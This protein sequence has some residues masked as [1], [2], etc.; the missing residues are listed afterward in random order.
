MSSKT[1]EIARRL[2]ELGQ[3]EQAQEAYFLVL[4]QA[5]ERQ[6]ELEMEAA[7]YLFFSEGN[8]RVAY[9]TFISL[10]NRG[11]YQAELLDLMTQAFYLPNVGKQRKQYEKNCERLNRYHYLFRKDF[12]PF[13]ELPI[14]FFPF[15]DEG[16]IP[17]YPAENR[18][19][20]Y[21]DFRHPVIDRYFF[22]DLEKPILAKDV[23]SQYQLEYLNDT[24]RKSEWVG[25]ENHIYLHYSDWAT[26][27][28]HL[29]CLDFTKQLRDSK[30]V[31]LIEDEITQYP[32]D[33]KERF[34]IDYSKYIPRRIGI[35]EVNRLIWQV[36]LSAHNGGNFFAEIMDG[37]PYLLTFP[38]I[39]FEKISKDIVEARSDL[40]K[41]SGKV[42][43]V[44]RAL[45]ELGNPSDK[46]ILVAYYMT[47]PE[48]KQALNRRSRIVPAIYFQPHFPDIA[49]K[50]AIDLEKNQTFLLSDQY[51]AIRQAPLFKQFKYVK[52][53]TP[54][55][56][57]TISYAATVRYTVDPKR[58]KERGVLADRV[59]ERVL[60][61]SFMIDWQDRLFQDSVLVRFE[62]GKLN[63]KATFTALAE[64]LD[65]P[66]TESMTYCS[67]FGE[68]DPESM[69]GD[70]RGFDPASVYRT[71]DEYANDDER[72]FLEY[73]LRDVY[74]AYGY[75]FHY[76]KGEPVDKAWVQARIAGF[77]CLD[78]HMEQSWEKFLDTD[79]EK[80]WTAEEAKQEIKK[81]IEGYHEN[82]WDVAKLLMRGLNFVNRRRQPL[83]MM[84]PLQL[85]P[86]LLEQP[87]YH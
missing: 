26:F 44:V 86:A 46:D 2:A 64:F 12:L 30:Q 47:I 54:M 15:D 25:R 8:Y 58:S 6:P 74:E 60:N 22:K 21:V 69:Q 4:Q 31:F 73:F 76:Y 87:L 77:T 53:Y 19:G 70:A 23:Y 35:R 59:V 36:Q 42:S 83:H 34:G 55:R 28:A 27:C 45:Q 39:M 50:L 79:P 57:P 29:Q 37:H 67:M 9:T 13:D 75:D 7:S 68:R 51:E 81:V 56:C 1:I 65:I 62:D 33:F 85:D 71:Y 32:I 52:S 41:A 38:P 84:K 82:R 16:F 3:K 10:Y 66:Y 72:A 63:P 18:F 40:K 14:L 43:E 24:V 5:A 11:C 80:A 49:Y 48:N 17:F 20:D 61:R 78:H